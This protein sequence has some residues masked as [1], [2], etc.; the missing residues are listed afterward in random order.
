MD[1]RVW[2]YMNI[3]MFL[4]LSLFFLD[5]VALS[6]FLPSVFDYI[7]IYIYIYI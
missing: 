3:S 7:Y 2:R 5:H 6:L 4:S 1:I